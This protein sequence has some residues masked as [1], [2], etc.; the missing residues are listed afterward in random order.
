MKKTANKNGNFIVW[1]SGNPA[2][3]THYYTENHITLMTRDF[4]DAKIF[5][6]EHDF[7]EMQKNPRVGQF[8]VYQA[9]LK[10]IA[11]WKLQNKVPS[12]RL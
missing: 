4:S 6:T 7:W 9:P 12:D 8:K 11:K 5:D 10:L 1:S 2:A 3:P